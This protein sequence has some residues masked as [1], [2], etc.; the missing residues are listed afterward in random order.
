L[1]YVFSFS[2]VVRRRR[3]CSSSVV[4]W[5]RIRGSGNKET[6]RDEGEKPSQENEQTEEST[7]TEEKPEKPK[8]DP[9]LLRKLRIYVLI[10]GGLSFVMSFIALSQ[11][12]TG[13]AETAGV[14]SEY[15]TRQGIDMGTF[16]AKYIRAGEVRRIIFCPDYARAVAFLHTGA[17]IDGRKVHEPVVVVAYPHS[18]QQFWADV[19]KEEE[20]MG[21]S[22]S[23]G[24]PMDMYRGMTVVRMIELAVGVL[25]L[26][27]LITQYGRLISRRIM[28]N[29]QKKSGGYVFF[30]FEDCYIFTE[31]ANMTDVMRD[32]IAQLMGR[33]KEDED[34]QIPIRSRTTPRRLDFLQTTT[35]L[36][37]SMHVKPYN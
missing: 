3:K 16:L 13:Q 35:H 34:V 25:I 19:R 36:K 24:V 37:Q 1:S 27:W 26:A 18:A 17:V 11:M 20:D 10:V 29:R 2:Q 33:Q 23:D 15:L 4:R 31:L 22:V 14:Q 9:A 21:I 28:A 5:I 12:A 8:V 6:D 32:M 7:S 30:V